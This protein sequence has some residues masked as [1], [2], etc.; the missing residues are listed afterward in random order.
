[1]IEM[2]V[3]KRLEGINGPI[4]LDCQLRIN[5]GEFA[6]LFGQSGAGKTTLLRMLAGL[7]TPDEGSIRVNGETWFDSL[8]KINL[9]PQQR[10]IGYVFQDHALFP[11]LSVRENLAF[12]LP[13]Q[14]NLAV[15]D[16]LLALT[17]LTGLQQRRPDTLSGGQRQRVGLARALARQPSILLLNPCRRWIAR[18]ARTYKM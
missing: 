6:A 9:K 7:T 3:R 15:I 4:T 16:D 18:R 14:S 17:E 1:M 5:A 8:R 12:A 2:H 11:H 13:K 10:R